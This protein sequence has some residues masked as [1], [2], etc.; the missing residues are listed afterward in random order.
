MLSEFIS[1]VYELSSSRTAARPITIADSF[2]AQ[3]NR[4]VKNRNRNIALMCPRRS[5]KTGGHVMFA[6][7]KLTS[8]PGYRLLYVHHT[9]LN[10]QQQ[11]L[12]PLINGERALK[13]DGLSVRGWS[14]NYNK[15]ELWA[16]MYNGSFVQAVGCDNIGDVGR[17]LGFLWDA[18]LI[19][20]MQ[21]FDDEVLELLVDKTILPTLID[22]AGRL[23]LSGTPP[24]IEAGYWHSILTNP[25]WD[26]VRWKMLEN[27]HITKENII[28]TMALRGFVIDFENETNN[29]PIVQREV[30][31][32]LTTD[33]S[34][35]MYEFTEGK[36]EYESLPTGDN[37]GNWRYS[38]GIDIGLEDA[39]AI[40]IAGWQDNDPEHRIYEV[41][42]F[43][44]NHQDVDQLSDEV[45]KAITLF[46][47]SI[48]VAD[49]GGHGATKVVKTLERRLGIKNTL[50]P[51]SVPD[52]VA[53]VNDEYRSGRMKIIKGGTLAEHS[54]KVS[55]DK[56]RKAQSAAFHSDPTEAWRYA[57][58]GACL[59][60]FFSA[61]A[62]P[63]VP[64]AAE[65]RVELIRLRRELQSKPW[66][67]SIKRKY[68]EMLETYRTVQP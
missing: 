17:K 5:G 16:R 39:D 44:E 20:E 59:A 9:R 42:S 35:L 58:H 27:P 33:K 11:F 49:T 56:K 7:D 57:H 28:S 36:N 2:P 14:Q 30:F 12:D 51:N 1:R 61:R 19:D 32:L 37:L 68:E 53:L 10:A 25:E 54:K 50:K 22:R 23:I 24:D 67:N 15:S 55:W 48:T 18:I 41:F 4:Y 46:H 45:E 29:H 6:A 66:D 38:M 26:Q 63:P 3:W 8:E 13:F 65:L 31:G 34:K 43:K 52:S 47:P 62:K 21:E 60:G 64:S 40:E